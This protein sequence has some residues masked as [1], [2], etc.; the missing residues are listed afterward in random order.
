[1]KVIKQTYNIKAP[2][3]KVWKALTDPK[4]IEEWG[5]GPAVMDSRK[6]QNFLYGRRY[7]WKILV[8][9]RIKTSAGMVRGKMG[10]AFYSLFTLTSNGDTTT[11]DLLHK[12]IPDSEASEIESGWK[13]YYMGSLKD[14]LKNSPKILPRLQLLDIKF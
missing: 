7:F 11:V 13:K 6:V 3:E 12:N 8:L 5:A 2:L 14:L 9:Y 1:M 10:S 4:V